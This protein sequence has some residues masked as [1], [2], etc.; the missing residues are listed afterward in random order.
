MN[1]ILRYVFLILTSKLST[2]KK[3][4][5]RQDDPYKQKERIDMNKL[6]QMIDIALHEGK[7]SP[8]LRRQIDQI[9]EIFNFAQHRELKI[10]AKPSLRAPNAPSYME[11]SLAKYR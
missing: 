11:E 8:S 7:V 3:D 6:G 4:E 10:E 5:T 1:S 9:T 2:L